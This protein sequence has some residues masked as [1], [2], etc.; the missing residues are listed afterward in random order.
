MSHSRKILSQ[1]GVSLADVYDVE[2]SVV[3]LENLDVSDIKG[4]HDL[5]PQIHSE[6]LIVFNLIADSTA[7]AQNVD[8]DVELAGFP[9]SINRLLSISVVVDVG[10]RVNLC[11]LAIR[12][13]DTLADHLIWIWDSSDDLETNVRWSNTGGT[14]ANILALRPITNVLGG[15]PTMIGRT[16]TTQAMPSLFF[17]GRTLGFGAGTVQAQCLI[18]V[19]RPDVG[20]PAP[21][22]PS[23]HGL[24]LPSW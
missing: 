21:G 2:G 23:S 12:E 24:P 9:D 5:G 7:L 17:R 4:V 10:A 14:V 20:N 22:A 3:G 8:W 13:P 11:S 16:G 1:A 18:Q 15:A 6:R 19:M